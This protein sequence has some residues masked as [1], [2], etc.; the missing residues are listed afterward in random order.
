M[1][2]IIKHQEVI[3][4]KTVNVLMAYKEAGRLVFN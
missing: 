1:N 2:V 3:T 4:V